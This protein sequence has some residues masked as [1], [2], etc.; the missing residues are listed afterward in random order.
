[1]RLAAVEGGGTTFVAAIAE[2]SPTNI[3]EREEWPTTNPAE[4]IGRVADWLAARSYDRLGIACF[5][6]V[7]LNRNSPTYG[8][9]TTTPKAGWRY[10]DVL[11]PLSA[12][13]PVVPCAFDTDVNGPAL[14]EY[15]HASVHGSSITSC[16]YITVGTGIG[17]G[18]VVR[19]FHDPAL[20]LLSA[21]SASLPRADQRR[22]RA[23]TYAP[24]R[25]PPVHAAPQGRRQFQ[26]AVGP[27]RVPVRRAY[28]R[29]DGR[30]ARHIDACWC[31]P[32][33]PRD[34]TR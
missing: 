11:G 4:T 20:P 9:I 27:A 8:Y 18:L 34:P 13:R 21:S 25:R 16:A 2:G 12:V 26:R 14:G 7:D 6:P 3:V 29:G 19:A 24:G 5:G 15:R 33:G 22:V 1:M 32:L 31:G 17:V 30:D 28:G 10:T 23:R